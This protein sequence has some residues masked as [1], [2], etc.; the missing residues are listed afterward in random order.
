MEIE[1]FG[2]FCGENLGVPVMNKLRE[3]AGN[4]NIDVEGVDNL[5]E[6]ADG[7]YILVCNHVKP[8][9]PIFKQ[10]GASPD[11]FVLERVVYDHTLRELKVVARCDR[12]R[13]VEGGYR[14]FQ[15]EYENPFM[16]G[17][18]TGMDLVPVKRIPTEGNG[19]FVKKAGEFIRAG[20]P[21]LI[22]P[23]GEHFEKFDED[24]VLKGGFELLARRFGVPVL[25][26][27][28]SGCDSWKVNSEVALMFGR[29]LFPDQHKKREMS[30]ELLRRM[31]QLKQ[32]LLS[33][34]VEAQM[35]SRKAVSALVID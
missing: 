3:R 32:L 27:F 17:L 12:G 31:L 10:S 19:D 1:Q 18:I 20:N 24:S 25:P 13:W 35:Q 6:I 4:F 33:D 15:K 22:Y 2:R 9:V 5:L 21:L 29:P 26:A 28:V 7:P 16:K 30:A 34:L 23:E 8:T 11:T 14:K